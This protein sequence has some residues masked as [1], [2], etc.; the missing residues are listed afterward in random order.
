MSDSEVSHFPSVAVIDWNGLRIPGHERLG[1][2]IDW[3][4]A[5]AGV[6]KSK[7]SPGN[8]AVS[9]SDV[10]WCLMFALG[11]YSEWHPMM[12]TSKSAYRA[13]VKLETHMLETHMLK[14]CHGFSSIFTGWLPGELKGSKMKFYGRGP[15]R[16]T[17]RMAR[18]V[19]LQHLWC[20]GC[21][22]WEHIHTLLVLE[23]KHISVSN[24]W[25][26]LQ[27]AVNI[28]IYIYTVNYSVIV[29]DELWIYDD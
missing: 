21:L 14:R 10:L 19:S 15:R 23:V 25:R 18:R 24:I 27:T 17:T 7:G 26:P 3:S 16:L 2:R 13:L 11:G 29:I 6:K 5:E 28:Y 20:A 4:W 8:W 1:R 9:C 22:C 12:L